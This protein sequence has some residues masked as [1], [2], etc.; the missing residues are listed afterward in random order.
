MLV[1]HETCNAELL[2]YLE[3]DLP[4]DSLEICYFS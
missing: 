4:S 3:L 1:I 2:H